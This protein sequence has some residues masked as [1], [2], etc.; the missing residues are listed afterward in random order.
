[1][2]AHS[3]PET[4]KH[5]LKKGNFQL[6]RQSALSIS[7]NTS[8]LTPIPYGGRVPVTNKSKKQRSPLLTNYILDFINSTYVTQITNGTAQYQHCISVVTRQRRSM[9]ADTALCASQ[10]HPSSFPPCIHS[11]FFADYEPTH[12]CEYAVH[13]Q[14]RHSA[15]SSSLSSPTSL[16]CTNYYDYLGKYAKPLCSKDQKCMWRNGTF[17]IWDAF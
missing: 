14:E 12:A 17:Y 15:Q 8:S 10:S 16:F 11:A 7:T 13:I 3:S 6:E 5:Q 9:D 2:D 4:S 1:M